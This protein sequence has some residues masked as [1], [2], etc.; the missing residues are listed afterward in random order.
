MSSQASN[1]DLWRQRKI[2]EFIYFK[3]LHRETS[4]Y[5][6]K[7][8]DKYTNIVSTDDSRTWLTL[9]EI[10]GKKY[11]FRCLNDCLRFGR[12]ESTGRLQELARF[13]LPTNTS[14]VWVDVSTDGLYVAFILRDLTTDTRV[15][16]YLNSRDGSTVSFGGIRY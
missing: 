8:E 2:E 3:E 7:E 5:F 4:T 11:V 10:N 6:A 14:I 12:Q 13:A 16:Y 1:L 9:R 15:G